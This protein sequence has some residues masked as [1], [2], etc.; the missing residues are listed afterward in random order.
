MYIYIDIYIYINSKQTISS[1]KKETGNHLFLEFFNVM[2]KQV[3]QPKYTPVYIFNLLY[4]YIQNKIRNMYLT[5]R[6]Y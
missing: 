4:I 6:S 3:I 1:K 2:K 5:Y